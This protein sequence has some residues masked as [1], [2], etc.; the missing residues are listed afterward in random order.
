[1]VWG[2]SI[3]HGFKPSHYN[4]CPSALG[5]D[6]Q[7]SLVILKVNLGLGINEVMVP[8]VQIRAKEVYV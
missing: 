3:T 6:F 5:L 2:L 8:L 1:M 7:V 4:S